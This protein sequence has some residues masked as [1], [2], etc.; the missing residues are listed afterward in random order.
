M[1]G[2][3]RAA[4]CGLV[5]TVVLLAGATT[6]VPAQED[7]TPFDQK[8]IQN[9]LGTLGLKS[10]GGGIDYRERSPLVL[11]PKIDLPAPQ[12][13]TA[14]G[15]PN[16]PVDAD[17]KRRRQESQRSPRDYIEE[18]R[19]LRPSELNVGQRQ[20]GRGPASPDEAGGK[21]SPS[22]LG[23]RGGILGSL[24]GNKEET[25]KFTEEP[26]RTSLTEPPV[27]YQTPS[28]DQ[29]YTARSESWLPKIPTLFDRDTFQK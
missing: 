10:G 11:P 19:A 17:Q 22:D 7:D 21:M 15:A 2:R 13:E 3:I 1:R 9:V 26:P 18:S 20:R 24:W 29:P 27:G 12:A 16:W 23:Y 14:A 4:A 25:P 28:P 8:I 5:G 6:P